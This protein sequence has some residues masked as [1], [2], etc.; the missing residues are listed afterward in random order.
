MLTVSRRLVFKIA[1][2]SGRF[3][4]RMYLLEVASVSQSVLARVMAIILTKLASILQQE[5][6]LALEATMLTGRQRS[7]LPS[8]PMPPTP[9]SPLGTARPP[10]LEP[11]MLTQS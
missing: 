1:G 5:Y 11:T 6:Q 2:M 10:A 7:A 3:G 4:M 9:S 8:A